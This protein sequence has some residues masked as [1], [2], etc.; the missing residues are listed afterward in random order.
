[1]ITDPTAQAGTIAAVNASLDDYAVVYANQPN[2][3]LAASTTPG[4]DANFAAVQATLVSTYPGSTEQINEFFTNF[5][6]R[7]VAVRTELLA[8]NNN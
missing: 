6:A 4:W 8:Y 3:N 7:R 5:N 2:L 1:M